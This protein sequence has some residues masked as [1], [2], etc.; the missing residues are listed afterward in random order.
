M[1]FGIGWVSVSPGSCDFPN[2]LIHRSGQAKMTRVPRTR[3]CLKYLEKNRKGNGPLGS[4]GSPLLSPRKGESVKPPRTGSGKLSKPAPDQRSDQSVLP[5]EGTGSKQDG[6]VIK[7]GLDPVRMYRYRDKI[8][9][10]LD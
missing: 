9:C 4:K 1:K 10:E 6:E 5:E 8:Q 3:R 2:Q 7:L